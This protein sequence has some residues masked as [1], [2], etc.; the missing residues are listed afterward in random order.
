MTM[1]DSTSTDKVKMRIQGISFGQILSGAYALLLAQEN[2]PYRLPIIVG[3]AEAQS[4]AIKM[5]GIIPPRPMTHDLFVSFSH[6]FGVT[7]RSVLINKFESGIFSAELTFSDGERTIVLDSRTS[8]AIAIAI[9]TQTPIYTT[10][11]ILQQAGY[12]SNKAEEEEDEDDTTEFTSSD[13]EYDSHTYTS[14]T[15]TEE[16]NRFEPKLENLAIE[17]LERK[18]AKLIETEN[19]EEAARVSE[20]IKAKRGK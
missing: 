11:E 15:R 9:R 17:E 7:L 3:S 19:Y 20:I 16:E 14:D 18:L 13:S 8:D 6:A 4:I 2:G 10:M 1:D 5:E 12:I